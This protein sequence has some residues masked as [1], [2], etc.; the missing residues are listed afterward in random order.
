V[1]LGFTE[2]YLFDRNIALGFDLYRRDYS[3]FNFINDDRNTTY[4]QVTTGGQIRAGVPLNEYMIMAFRY[5]LN[6][7]N[8]TLDEDTFF[9]DPD[10]PGGNPPVCDPVKAGFYLCDAIGSNI[11]ST[12]GYSFSFSNLNNSLRPS[13][14][15]RFTLSQDFAVPGTP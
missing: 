4:K 2:P 9:S 13:R 15:H 11:T 6:E 14:G 8:V 10:G 5:G 12:I 7:D 3:S 1:E